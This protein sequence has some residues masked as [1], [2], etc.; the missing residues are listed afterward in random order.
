[1]SNT[2]QGSISFAEGPTFYSQMDQDHFFAWLQSI[3]GVKEV[4]GTGRAMELVVGR[5]MDKESLRD[6]IALMVRYRMNCRPLKPLCDEQEDE[7]FRDKRK[8]W[9]SAVYG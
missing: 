9:Y 5:P 4:G 1:M 8:Y 2:S 3:S 7:G 6:L